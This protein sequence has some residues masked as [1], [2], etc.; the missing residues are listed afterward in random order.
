[1]M[2]S[3]RAPRSLIQEAIACVE[4]RA[5]KREKHKFSLSAWIVDAM[6]EKVLHSKRNKK[7]RPIRPR[8]RKGGKS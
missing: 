4:S 8:P 5:K 7:K 1:V 2:L 3:F 6:R